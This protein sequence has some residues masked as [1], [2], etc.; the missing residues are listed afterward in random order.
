MGRDTD[1]S[2]EAR[3]KPPQIEAFGRALR[4]MN[5]SGIR[6][7]IAGAF[8]GHAYTG[9]W[10]NTNDLDIFLKAEN[11]AGALVA[12]QQAGFETRVEDGHWIA[13]AFW[14]SY[15][16]DL[17]FGMSNGLMQVTDDWFHGC[18]MATIAG[19]SA[20]LIPLEELV[21]AKVYIAL[22]ERFDGA[23]VAHLI[24]SSKG[25]IDW[26]R[27]LARLGENRGLL[28][29][30]FIFFDYVYPGH[31][32]YLPQELAERLYE[33]MRARWKSPGDSR[34]FRGMLLDPYSFNVD[35]N[36]WGYEDERNMWQAID[37]EGRAL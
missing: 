1:F 14:D 9:I 35:V 12:L 24:R 15:L 4:V 3:L 28:L 10:R 32:D 5:A 27:V 31:T 29:W 13:K 34:S 20:R 11:V 25:H 17:I 33:E 6:Y 19:E 22:R 23:D 8:A 16:I 26:N 2:F 37:E 18:R 30:H 7:L 36:Y 21:A